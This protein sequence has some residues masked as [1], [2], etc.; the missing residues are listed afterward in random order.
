MKTVLLDLREVMNVLVIHFKIM[1]VFM[2]LITFYSGKNALIFK[3]ESLVTGSK[4]DLVGTWNSNEP[5]IEVEKF[6]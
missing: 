6:F 5:K 1:C 3:I 4:L 2:S